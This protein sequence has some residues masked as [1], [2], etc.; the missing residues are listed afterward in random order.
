VTHV[1][2]ICHGRGSRV[3]ALWLHGDAFLM[4]RLHLLWEGTYP[5]R[6]IHCVG[7][8]SPN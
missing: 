3:R 2:C 8:P 6:R 4:K 7:R 1:F 5:R